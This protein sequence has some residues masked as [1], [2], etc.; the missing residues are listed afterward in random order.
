[1]DH[2]AALPIDVA[3]VPG[4]GGLI[5]MSCCPGRQ[6]AGFDPL[7]SRRDLCGDL[8]TIRD[9]GAR[10][11]VTLTQTHELQLL[12]VPDLGASTGDYG[13]QWLHAP[14]IDLGAPGPD[15]EAVW[16]GAD[17]QVY[18]PLR[19]GGRILLHCRAGLGRTGTVAARLMIEFGAEPQAAL[20]AVRQARPG[21]VENPEQVEYVL[22]LAH[23]QG[24]ARHPEETDG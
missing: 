5:G 15:F 11:V 17:P 19:E 18:Q 12:G 2:P 21:A 16:R 6:E 23:L 13:L 1:M 7:T 24:T 4:T 3:R 22:N 20:T 9:W 10:S 14:I 8:A